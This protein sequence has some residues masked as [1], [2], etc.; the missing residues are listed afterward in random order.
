MKRA[1]FTLTEVLV[2][3]CIAVAFL[4][5]LSGLELTSIRRLDAL[6]ARE[7]ATLVAQETLNRL[8]AETDQARAPDKQSFTAVRQGRSY[9]VAVEV[10][11]QTG[12]YAQHSYQVDVSVRW[13][14]HV[15]K[16][17]TLMTPC[18]VP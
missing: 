12:I 9:Q 1:G 5:V 4:L 16:R 6:S 8:R 11:A 18:G 3:L 14:A 13:D 15:M 7:E 17:S 2:S 10:T